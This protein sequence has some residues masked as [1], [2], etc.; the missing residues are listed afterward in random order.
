MSKPGQNNQKG[1]YAQNLAAMCLFLQLL[2]DTGFSYIQLEPDNSEDFDLIFKDGKKIICESKFRKEKF[3]Y[4]Q[5]KELLT[6]ICQRKSINDRDEILVICKSANSDLISEVKNIRFFEPLKDKFIN[7][8]GFGDQLIKTLPLV[9]FWVIPKGFNREVNYSLLSELINMWLPSEDVERFVDSILLNEIQISS[10]QGGVY[11]RSDFESDINE[12]KKEVKQR[13]DYFSNKVVKE[14]Q[15]KKLEKDIS[16]NKGI[17]WGSGSIAAFSVQWDLMSFAMDRLKTRNDL[18]LNKWN[19]LWQL[20]KVYYFAFGIFHVFENNLQSEENKNYI[21]SYIKKHVKDIRGFYRSDFFNV[22]VVKIITKIIESDSENKYLADTF[23]VIKDL[24]TVNKKEFFYL[25]DRGHDRGQ[26]EKEEICKLLHKIYDHADAEL[27]NKIFNLIITSF[28]ITEDEGEFSHY[29]P[30][31]VYEI[32]LKWLN[33]DLTHRLPKLTEVIS[34]QY[35][36]F[37]KKLSKNIEFK[38]WEHIGGVTTYWGNDYRVSDRHFIIHLL[39]PA[40]KKFYDH[41]ND[42]A[43]RFIKSKCISKKENI[44]RTRPD[45]LNRSVYEIVLNRYSSNDKNTSKEASG[46]LKEFIYSRKGIPHKTD[47]IYQ[48]IINSN[49]PDNKKWKLVELTTRKY[50]VPINPFAERIVTNLAQKDHQKAK[51]EL[52]K[53]FSEPKYYS[54]QFM[55]GTDSVTSIRTLLET[56]TD[57][58]ID[59]FKKL[60]TTDNVRSGD[61]DHFSA[62]DIA[63]LLNDIVKMDYAKGLSIFRSL[64]AERNLS[65]DQQIIYAF[66]LFDYHGKDESDDPKLLTAIYNDVV[67]PF[68]NA[69]GNDITLICNRI[70]YDTCR[71]AF[72]QFAVRLIAKKKISEALRIIRIFVSDPDPYLPGTDPNDKNDE[73]N[74]HKKIENGEKPI[75]ITSVRGQCGWALMKCAVLAGREQIPEIINLSGKLANDENYYV[76]HMACFI[77]SQLARNRLSV[78]PTDSQTLFFNDNKVKALAMAKEVEKIVFCLF[79]RFISWP[80]PVQKSMAKSILSVFEHIRALNESD[81][82]KLVTALT[83]CPKA[84][85]NDAAPLFIYFAEFRKEAYKK[86]RFSASGFYDDLGPDKYD[87]TIFKKILIE[88]IEAIQK[89]DPDA[90]FRFATAFEHMIR[91]KASNN[92]EDRKVTKIA[93][94]YFDLL[95]NV[96]SHNVFDLIYQIIKDKISKEEENFNVWY[97][98]YFKCLQIEREFYDKNFVPGETTDMYWWPSF[99]NSDILE[100]IYHRGNKEKFIKVAAIIFSFPKEL[101]IH[102]TDNIIAVLKTFPKTDKRV[103]NIFQRLLERNP[104][105]YW[106]FAGVLHN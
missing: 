5:L 73:F 65:K 19:D 78:L 104:S 81:S 97:R 41:D 99:C 3:S 70:S 79:D 43:W 23:D 39:A 66:S 18:D 36:L 69:F 83:K 89:Q 67:D 68:L 11:S 105:K 88:T 64:E 60:I 42:K 40:I 46:I 62:F 59:L 32:L 53:W 34:N 50:N 101:E 22:N 74:E 91:D 7:Q 15:F 27:R 84:I 30:K 55:L 85:I 103:L 48:A 94:N 4:P 10:T 98:L 57:L 35:N 38:G 2:R 31:T 49:I 29:A 77:L 21:L 16:N 54:N 106:G 33:E 28:N 61:S 8:Y 87:S 37:Y 58:A 80:D 17:D 25:K 45:F 93:L 1:I 63:G 52:I 26:W 76:I 24:I 71:E 6:K 102:E 9:N 20:N 100:L 75:T 12:F 47:L 90:C 13:S 96:Y 95:T 44:S 82:L 56:K 72:V 51:A 86:W 92:K 14:K